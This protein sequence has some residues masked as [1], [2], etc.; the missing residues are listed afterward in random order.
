MREPMDVITQPNVRRVVNMKGA[1]IAYTECLNNTA[2]YFMDQDPC[3]ILVI[4]PTVEMAEAWSKDRLSPMLRDTPALSNKVKDPRSR[5]SGNTLRQKVYPGGRLNIIGANAPSGLA[6]RPIRIVLADEVDRYPKSAGTE[7]DPLALASK[8][9]LTFWNR[10]TLIGST[11]TIKGASVVEREYEA[12]DKRR[13]FV[14]CPHCEHEQVIRWQQVR[15]DKEGEGDQK[16]H[17]PET[18]QYVCESC[19]CIWTEAERQ[20][21][22][23][24][25]RWKAE[26]PFAGVAGF[27][28]PGLLS[29]WQSLQDIVQD[30]L[31]SKDDPQLLQVWINT[32]LGE[33]WEEKGEGVEGGALLGRAE[34][35]DH[36][37]LPDQV[38]LLTAGV[39]VQDD[40]L[41][42][43]VVGWG[44]YEEAWPC[45][46]EVIL[47][48]PAQ[49]QV[50]DDLDV[51]LLQSF[52]TQ[53]GRVL[54]I[55]AGSIDTGGHHGEMVYAFCRR[56]MARRIYPTKGQAG[57][58]Q[59]WPK[60][61]SK[62]RKNDT[63]YVIGV[64]TAKEAIYGRLRIQKPGKGFI[65]FPTADGFDDKY[66][67]QLTSEQVMTKWKAGRPYREWVLPAKRRN[68]AL[69]TFVL[70]LAAL[71]SLPVRLDQAAPTPTSA[72]ETPL[73]DDK[74][75]RPDVPE[76]EEDDEPVPPPPASPPPPA[77]KQRRPIRRSHRST[78]MGR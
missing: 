26:K 18:A 38:L 68:E 36:E 69:D 32:V 73:I 70:A 2:A 20:D 39:D 77:L 42:V 30:F 63:V 64:D 14:P 71:K 55:R 15:W 51:I 61:G 23:A 34:A 62:T 1:Q 59:I 10:K 60:R 3:P 50:W 24:K 78:F 13:W 33:S 65:H 25:G 37:S 44:R 47:G 5:D 4:Q 41:E 11:P 31:D 52:R 49:Q 35:Y 8:R 17:K 45:L 29:P 56:R 22:I 28:I 7:G 19:G 12:S 58:R 48:D 40:R 54:R 57:A 75:G 9:Q 76:P 21:A 74:R 72:T 53:G 66:I 6:S 16:T 67:A 27:H 43:Q 46:Y